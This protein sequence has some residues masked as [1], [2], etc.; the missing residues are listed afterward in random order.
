MAKRRYRRFK[1]RS[2]RWS[3]NLEQVVDSFVVNSTGQFAY[4]RALVTNNTST[5]PGSI[6][7]VFTVKN[8]EMS[9]NL[10]YQSITDISLIE[11]LTCYIMYIPEG[12]DINNLGS[13]FPQRHPEWIMNYKYIGSPTNESI[14][15]TPTTVAGSIGQQYQPIRVKTRMARKLNTGDRIVLITQGFIQGTTIPT[16]P[17]QLYGVLRWWTKAN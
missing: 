1:R 17:I 7:Q 16:S 14:P 2:A 8:I 6:A 4:T 5:N 12:F 11:A 15:S 13:D 9:F 3:P 10:D